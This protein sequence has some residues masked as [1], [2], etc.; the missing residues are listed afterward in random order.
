MNF[1]I[2]FRPGKP[3]GILLLL[4]VSILLACDKPPTRQEELNP[5]SRKEPEDVLIG[6]VDLNG[7]AKKDHIY[8]M[9]PGSDSAS[10]VRVELSNHQKYIFAPDWGPIDCGRQDVSIAGDSV[11]IVQA[12]MTGSSDVSRIRFDEN[13]PLFVYHDFATRYSVDAED[14]AEG[15]RTYKDTTK[16]YE[17][18]AD[19]PD[20]YRGSILIAP[21]TER[22]PVQY[23]RTW[24]SWIRKGVKAKDN[25]TI[26]VSA[27]QT[28]KFVTVRIGIS[29]DRDTRSIGTGLSDILNADHIELWWLDEWGDGID[30][31]AHAAQLGLARDTEG[32]PVQAWFRKPVHSV[33]FP[34]VRWNSEN[35]VEI[36]IPQRW[37]GFQYEGQAVPFTVVYS[38]SDGDGQKSL[39]ST[40][41]RL[42]S[43]NN[44]A[45]LVLTP[46]GQR[47]PRLNPKASNLSIPFEPSSP[48]RNGSGDQFQPY[49]LGRQ[50][51]TLE[52]E[53][54]G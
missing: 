44:L 51:R 36:D 52:K 46:G 11:E 49:T 10:S 21:Q 27:I 9:P 32:K 15:P 31:S 18:T 35:T 53:H 8:C 50:H 24:Q 12:G 45:R 39:L 5:D 16:E 38:D 37:P 1:N 26:Q 25:D 40:T 34:T 43:P 3:R 30:R 42:P 20:I 7:D 54:G 28:G 14:F 17:G 41:D 4:G 19:S 6:S 23:A 48:D 13:G 29:D 22:K 33:P 2:Y 47:Y